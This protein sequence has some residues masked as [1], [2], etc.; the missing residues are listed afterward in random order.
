MLDIH[1]FP[2][3]YYPACW[4]IVIFVFLVSYMLD[5]AV[6][7]ART[8]GLLQEVNLSTIIL[9]CVLLVLMFLCFVLVPVLF[10][11]HPSS[12]SKLKIN[13]PEYSKIWIMHKLSNSH[14]Y[15]YLTFLLLSTVK[16]IL[17]VWFVKPKILFR[18]CKIV[19]WSV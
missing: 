1:F 4:I 10:F 7:N 12:L 16:P 15:R 11:L 13:I 6:V 17:S 9:V 14:S 3:S 2:F 8:I 5:I 19:N 18:S